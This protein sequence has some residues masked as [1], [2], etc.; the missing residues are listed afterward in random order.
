MEGL[1]LLFRPDF[2]KLASFEIWIAAVSQLF[3][4]VSAGLGTLTTYASFN[5]QHMPVVT[6]SVV[7]CFCNAA[8]SILSGAVL[9]RSHACAIPARTAR[10]GAG[11][12]VL[13]V[14]APT[15]QA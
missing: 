13:C 8:F 6:A 1:R 10:A 4:G 5:P 7:L 14:L 9:P 12:D 3:F 11:R 2:S 15:L